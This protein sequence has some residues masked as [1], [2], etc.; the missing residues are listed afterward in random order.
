MT[1]S[2]M[3]S[4]SGPDVW[5]TAN[6][7]LGED[8]ERDAELI[9]RHNGLVEARDVVWIMG[10]AVVGDL[11]ALDRVRGIQGRKMLIAGPDDACFAG[12]VDNPKTLA[13]LSARYRDAGFES[14]VTGAAVARSGWTMR[15]QLGPNR[16]CLWLSHF[17]Y[18]R[19][20]DTEYAVY[21]PKRPARGPVP[22]LL[23]GAAGAEWDSRDRMIDVSVDTWKSPVP[24]EIINETIEQ[25]EGQ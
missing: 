10:A 20:E 18:A 8:A 1:N 13:T 4:R 23:C 21:R 5:F 19:P 11:G 25:G 9:D 7:R 24:L 14:V 22:W 15:V 12:N 17:P 3:F 16:S 6:W 2:L